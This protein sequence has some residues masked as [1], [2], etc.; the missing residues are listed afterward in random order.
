MEQKKSK[1]APRPRTLPPVPQWLPEHRMA[2]DACAI[3]DDIVALALLRALRDLRLWEMSPPG[4]RQ[5][6]LLP[7]SRDRIEAIEHV[8]QEARGIAEALQD[9][10]VMRSDPEC[11]RP[12]QL[13]AACRCISRWADRQSLAH[14]GLLFAEAAARVDAGAAVR[15]REAG[16]A[17][18]RVGAPDRS[19]SW[20]DRAIRIA[21][22]DG[23]RNRIELI[24][25]LLSYG[26]LLREQRK[27][28]EARSVLSRAARLAASTRRHRV[29]AET[30]HDL[31]GL[32]IEAGTYAESERH[33][34]EALRHYPIHHPAVPA[35]VHDWS[36]LLVR[37]GLYRQAQPLVEAVLPQCQHPGLKLLVWGMTG[38]V[39]AA[40]GDR[41][42]YDL[43]V[44]HVRT[45]ASRTQEF[46][47]AAHGN[48]A[49]G[50]R[51]WREWDLARSLATHAI[52]ISKDRRELEVE[53]DVR[54][55]LAGIEAREP[56]SPRGGLP[57][58][59]RID[60]VAGQ[61]LSLLDARKRPPRR[62]VQIDKE[63]ADDSFDSSPE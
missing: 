5:W 28:D 50:A 4:E 17:A 41:Q 59:N 25:A 12:A 34:L 40:A 57:A 21:G 37:L 19:E 61:M 10:S 16:R 9:L 22:R 3:G 24:R 33:V 48:L 6:L 47:A 54:E 55:F 13:S 32:A 52:D 39:A 1:R 62:P 56:P 63:E 15:A 18:R 27:H 58:S 29:A 49:Q 23:N 38:L 36:F 8:S 60:G 44:S 11:V 42:R 43:A 53:Y 46:A 26:S 30:Q 45:L 31:L 51:F 14:T 7:P 2:E 20:L 35:L